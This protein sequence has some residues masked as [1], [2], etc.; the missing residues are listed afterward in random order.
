MD[1]PWSQQCREFFI[2][3]GIL[4]GRSRTHG[5][6]CMLIPDTYPADDRIS[7]APHYTSSLDAISKLIDQTFKGKGSTQINTIN[8]D[9]VWYEAT[10]IRWQ[11]GISGKAEQHR[12]INCESSLPIALCIAFLKAFKV[13][14]EGRR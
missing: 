3:D 6:V 11:N 5:D 2:E 9:N 13:E 1:K 4:L 7:Y 8:N 10:I 12:A 14:M